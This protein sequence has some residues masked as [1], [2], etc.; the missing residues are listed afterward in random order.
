[1]TQTTSEIVNVLTNMKEVLKGELFDFAQRTTLEPIY[2]EKAE[3]KWNVVEI[4][5]IQLNDD[6]LKGYLLNSYDIVDYDHETESL[7]VKREIF[8]LENGELLIFHHVEDY[9]E[10][11]DTFFTFLKRE[12]AVDQT[13]TE[14]EFASVIGILTGEIKN[15]SIE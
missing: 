3:E 10:E 13:L 5:Y 7:S 15:S 2:L 9:F 1:M 11:S 12:L 4:K 6:Y 8:L 14:K